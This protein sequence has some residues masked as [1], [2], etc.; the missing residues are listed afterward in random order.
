MNEQST[1]GEPK[2]SSPFQSEIGSFL[3]ELGL[4]MEPTVVDGET[5][6]G[7][8]EWYRVTDE[9]LAKLQDKYVVVSNDQIRLEASVPAVQKKAK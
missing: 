5:D 7:G 8:D 4:D 1:S 9:F 3:Q 2:S 6:W